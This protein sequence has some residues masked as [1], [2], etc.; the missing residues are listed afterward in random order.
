MTTVDTLPCVGDVEQRARDILGLLDLSIIWDLCCPP[1]CWRCAL[2]IEHMGDPCYYIGWETDM[3]AGIWEGNH[4]RT[5]EAA[6]AWV[7]EHERVLV[8]E[9]KEGY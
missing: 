3:S 4:F 7:V 6:Y 5:I 9:S 1:E 2:N 8:G